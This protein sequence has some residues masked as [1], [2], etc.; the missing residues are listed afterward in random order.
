V[1]LTEEEARKIAHSIAFGHAYWEHATNLAESGELM[2]ESSFEALI[3][4]TLLNPEKSRCLIANRV[5]FWNATEGFLVIF[6][7]ADPDLGTAYWPGK[8]VDGYKKLR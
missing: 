2:T 7:P 6:N 8:G 3:L 5:A 4:E 1:N